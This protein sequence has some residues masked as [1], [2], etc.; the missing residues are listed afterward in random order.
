MMSLLEFADMS[1]T[2]ATKAQIKTALACFLEYVQTGTADTR[3]KTRMRSDDEYAQL[4]MQS[5][6]YIQSGRDYPADL[7]R[8]TMAYKD[9]WSPNTIRGR[10]NFARQWLELN[11]IPFKAAHLKMLK[12]RIPRQ[13]TLTEDEVLNHDIIRQWIDHMKLHGR[14]IVLCLMSSGMRIGELLALRMEDVGW[15]HDPVDVTVREETAKNNRERYTFLSPEAVEGIKEWLKVRDRW[16]VSATN[17]GNGIGQTKRLDDDR[18]FP[19]SQMT[20]NRIFKTAL[21]SA[22]LYEVDPKTGR[23]TI[24]AHGLRKFFYTQMNTAMDDPKIVDLLVGHTGYL[25]P[26]YYKKTREEVGKLYHKA[27]YAISLYASENIPEI[28]AERESMSHSLQYLMSDN[29]KKESEIQQLNAKLEK[30]ERIQSDMQ[31]ITQALKDR[32]ELDN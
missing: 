26:V 29:I 20:I 32:G 13:K 18:I 15:D 25:E 14:V 11:D 19:F 31:K 27:Y 4:N 1:Q 28:K 30:I 2:K 7:L 23:A 6:E 3:L 12:T 8:F 21:E 17:R 16:M 9:I 22:G 10:V 5:I 24:H